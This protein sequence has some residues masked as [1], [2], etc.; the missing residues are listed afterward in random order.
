MEEIKLRCPECKEPRMIEVDG[1]EVFYRC[2][3]DFQLGLHTRLSRTLHPSLWKPKF[4]GIGE[5]NPPSLAPTQSKFPTLMRA[6]K[7]RAL[8]ALH[9]FA[10]ASGADKYSLPDS[11]SQSK[12]LFIRGPEMSHK[13]LMI[14]SIKMLAAVLNITVTPLPGDFDV[15]KSDI[16]E[17]E[18]T[19]M[20]GAEAKLR[21]FER[22]EVPKIMCLD[23]VRA[24]F[25]LVP[26]PAGSK[27]TS[28]RAPKEI[29]GF[30][31]VDRL[32]AV[33]ASRP[34]SLVLSSTDFIGE[35]GETC[36]ERL[37]DILA[38]QRT[39][40]ILLFHPDES[41]D[42]LDALFKKVWAD[43]N[44]ILTMRQDG[45][46]TKAEQLTD[47]QKIES[48]VD[49]LYFEETFKVVRDPTGREESRDVRETMGG[50]LA[51]SYPKKLQDAFR[52]FEVSVREQ[53]HEYRLGVKQA[54]NNWCS[55]SPK[56]QQSLS[57]PEREE[58]G[59]ILMLACETQ[60]EIDS[61]ARSAMA[62]RALMGGRKNA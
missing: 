15:F 48:L 47:E 1:K 42:I 17:A 30:E 26:R 61:Q 53:N 31:Q 40:L 58:V 52:R 23:N 7:I 59:R 34:G 44:L 28:E 32:M 55:C 51:Q 49:A 9:S 10:F 18:S 29:R 27:M 54:L 5:W 16:A 6:Q 21:V 35:I 45:N 57:M 20:A 8:S 2:Q 41:A 36:G 22:Y 14:S 11:I 12:N 33:R 43:N 37:F 46:K 56:W 50:S 25:R 13:A 24:S 60:E 3:C 62:L 4:R 19:N 38:S 39:S